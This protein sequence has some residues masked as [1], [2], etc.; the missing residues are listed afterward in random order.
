MTE[1]NGVVEGLIIWGD[2]TAVGI[3]GGVCQ[4]STTVFR[5]AFFGG[6]PMVERWAHGYVV[7]WYGEPGY[8]ATIYEP[9]VDFKFRNDTS[10]HLLIQTEVDSQNGTLTFSFYGTR[11]DREVEVVE[12]TVQNVRDA[13]PPVYQEDSSLQPGEE[14]QVD[15]PKKGMDVSVTRVVKEDGEVLREDTFVSRY[16]PWAAV[17]LVGPEKETPPEDDVET[18]EVKT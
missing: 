5:A 6:F 14:K 16:Q 4:V 3:G 18:D 15:W 1:E 17:Y 7:S 10:A 8:D 11:P 12:Y 13:P 2:R 9:Q